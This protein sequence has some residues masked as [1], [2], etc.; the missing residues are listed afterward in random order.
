[1]KNERD[2]KKVYVIVLHFGNFSKTL[3]CLLELH[4]TKSFHNLTILVVDNNSNTFDLKKLSPFPLVKI[5]TNEKNLGWSGGNNKGIRHAL[6]N[7]SDAVF[8]INNDVVIRVSQIDMLI[9][10]LFSKPTIGIVGP[11]SYFL[12]EKNIIADAG[13]VIKRNRFF[14]INRGHKKKD[15][16]QFKKTEKIDF[17]SGSAMLIKT[18]VLKKIGLFDE[19]FFLYYEDADFSFRAK[20][21]G[22]ESYVIGEAVANHEFGAS[23]KMGSPLHNYYTTRN[24]L[25]FLEMHAPFKTKL[26]EYL[27]LPK[28][29]F[30][31]INS[32]QIKKRY[33]LLGIRDYMLRRFGQQTYW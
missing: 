14:G 21:F 27:R 31:L 18:E 22:F 6:K 3:R 20:K 12:K 9:N 24:H 7:D 23:S 29:I 17:V 26:K 15:S 30:E 19:R 11:K 10:S 1:M 8:L 33:S 32:D 13:G 5:F 16:T 25:L 4:K 2:K 28:T